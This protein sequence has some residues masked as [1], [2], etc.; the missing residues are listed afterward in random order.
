TRGQV[1]VFVPGSTAAVTTIEFEPGA[2]RDLNEA[3]ERLAPSD[4]SY[5]HDLRWGDGN[6][7]SHLRAALLGPSLSIPVATGGCVIGTWQQI[8]LVECDLRPR[9]R[10]VV[11][12]FVGHADGED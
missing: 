9:S 6:G 10:R 4:G 3:L 7:F 5:H 2:L 1:T 12:S 8:V 11:L